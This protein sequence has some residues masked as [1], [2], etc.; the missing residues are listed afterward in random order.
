M[1]KVTRSVYRAHCHAGQVDAAVAALQ[2]R[3]ALL[4][5]QLDAENLLTI[6]LFQWERH[7][8]AYW[9]SIGQPL[10]PTT[11]FGDMHE[12][13]AVWPGTPEP[14]TFVP[15]L[16]I[17]HGLEPRDV[18]QW[19]RR[20]PVERIQ[21]RITRLKPTMASSYIFYHYQLQEE[22]P[23]HHDKYWQINQHEDLLFFYQ[24]L[25]PTPE[26][27]TGK[28]STSNTPPDWQTLMFP[29]FQLW[30]DAPPGEEIWRQV[31]LILHLMAP[32]LP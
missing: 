28:L 15:M 14:R 20:R 16:D 1:N 29:H 9:E 21:G 19:R 31:S 2:A 26:P 17:F 18:E 5:A 22:K 25:P 32:I 30:E 7:I 27:Q 12:Q 13:L 3:R 4:Q 23:G 24:E 8:F 10:V 6:S 11:L